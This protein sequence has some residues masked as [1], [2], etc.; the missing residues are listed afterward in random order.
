LVCSQGLDLLRPLADGLSPTVAEMPE[1]LLT[2]S[3]I[4][5]LHEP[6][7]PSAWRRVLEAHG[8]L[9]NR[10]LGILGLGHR[11]REL[12]LERVQVVLRSLQP[13]GQTGGGPVPLGGR[14]GIALAGRLLGLQQRLLGEFASLAGI[15]GRVLDLALQLG[16]MGNDLGGL[17]AKFLIAL[18]GL[19][20]G[21]LDLDLGI[22]RRLGLH[23]K[24][25]LE[26]VPET[27]EHES[28]P[29]VCGPRV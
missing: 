15:L 28:S 13:H 11:R 25:R 1:A 6:T 16:A 12:A 23:P 3:C 9:L 19:R 21:L 22:H 18:A 8:V 2:D 26:I 10:L 14:C 17:I 4:C 29:A 20:N 5:P 7:S 27:L 24:E